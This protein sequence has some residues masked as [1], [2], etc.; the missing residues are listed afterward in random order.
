MT[1]EQADRIVAN[2]NDPEFSPG[3]SMIRV[4]GGSKLA[5]GQAR[6]WW[7]GDVI[8]LSMKH[9]LRCED[10]ERRVI[11]SPTL[12]RERFERECLGRWP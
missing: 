1:P 11:M 12:G 9:R 6:D 2:L 4:M 3:A 8:Q 10:E 5:M 7:N